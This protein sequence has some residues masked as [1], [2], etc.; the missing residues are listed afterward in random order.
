[1]QEIDSALPL[2]G[3]GLAQ[4]PNGSGQIRMESL[5]AVGSRLLRQ[6][7][8]SC[9]AKASELLQASCL[10]EEFLSQYTGARGLAS[11]SVLLAVPPGTDTEFE[12]GPRASSDHHVRVMMAF[13]PPE[14]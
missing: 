9:W 7:N 5:A 10:F 6:A 13:R 12:T 14:A 3:S 2:G 4:L 8:D 1:M 11:K